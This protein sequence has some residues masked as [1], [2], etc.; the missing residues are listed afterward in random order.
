MLDR[1]LR[2]VLAG[3]G[4]AGVQVLLQLGHLGDQLCGAHCEAYPPAGHGERLGNAVDDQRAFLHAGTLRDGGGGDAV[5]DKRPIDFVADDQ[6]VVF[7]RHPGDLLQLRAAEHHAGGI[8]GRVQHQDPAVGGQGLPDALG[9]DPEALL[10]DGADVADLPAHK[11]CQLK[12]VQ[13]DG[14]LDEDALPRFDDAHQG[15]RERV[16]RADRQ[17]TSVSGS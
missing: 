13:P 6:Q 11:F 10:G 7:D 9:A 14:V 16:D 2:G 1:P 17:M 5:V 4:D 3:G 8:A 15:E 12:V